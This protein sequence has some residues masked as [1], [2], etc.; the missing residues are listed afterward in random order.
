MKRTV[1]VLAIATIAAVAATLTACGEESSEPNT[2]ASAAPTLVDT[3]WALTAYT[4]DGETE[5]SPV[6]DGVAVTA[7]FGEDRVTGSGGC[8]TYNATYSVTGFSITIETLASTLIGCEGE[9]ADIEATYFRALEESASFSVVGD[10]LMLSDA[11]ERTLLTFDRTADVPLTDTAWVATGI[12]NGKNAATSLL[13]DTTV[14]ATFGKDETVTGGSGCN[15]YNAPYTTDGDS[16]TIGGLLSTE[17]ACGADVMAQEVEY[18]AALGRVTNY[19]IEGESLR[20]TDK[21][22][23]LQVSFTVQ[24]DT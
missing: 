7:T 11:D 9:S 24:Q 18:R 20:L 22:G 15:T 23:A 5:P 12:N 6:P 1:R 14:T 3:S 4:P 19:E 21:D 10:T 2:S 17:M 16:I 13:P 8:N